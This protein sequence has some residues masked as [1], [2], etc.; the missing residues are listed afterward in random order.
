MINFFLAPKI[1]LFQN[2]NNTINYKSVYKEPGFKAIY[3]GNNVTKDVV[4]T[5]KVNSKK[6]GNYKIKYKI[7]EG[8]FT[9]E[10]TRVVK[11]RD[12][13]KPTIVLENEDSNIYVC[14]DKKYK[15][16]K[17]V[18]FDNYDGNITKNV[19]ITLRKN[20]VTYAVTD[21]SGNYT[22]ITKK[23]YY[24]DN[25][26]PNLK[27]HGDNYINL[28]LN[29]KYEELG[30]E[31]LDDCDGNIT[32]N[33]I[34]D[35]TVDTTKTGKYELVYHVT[36]SS[37]NKAEIKRVVNVI[38]KN[39]NGTIYLTF[40]DGPRTGVTNIILDILKEEGVKATFFVTNNG[41]DELIKREYDEGHTVALHT[42]SHN[43]AY[44][45]ASSEN[46]FND[47]ETVHQRVLRIT[48]YDSRIIRFPGGS[49][50]TISKRYQLGIMS[51]LTKEVLNRSYRYYDWNI[52]SGDAGETDEKE[53]VYQ[54]VIEHLSLDKVN[55]IL[56]HDIK[57][58]TRDALKDIIE[59]GKKH[60]YIFD[61]IQNDTEM[62]TQRV[63]N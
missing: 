32:K 44:I 62:V 51:Y 1:I 5:G 22:I 4:I 3:K 55:V 27:L 20:T 6:L 49:S 42:A 12:I 56:M 52:N 11:V 13:E 39:Q 16:E 63:N 21:Q 15:N 58:H 46:Y 38:K 40:D 34:I 43:Y 17:V 2:K 47:L 61:K 54:N 28:Y 36:D 48:G 59:Y 26:K 30:Y 41:P 25:E 31:A 14:P 37:N 23:I 8:Y 50:N 53:G 19:K 33:V 60:G 7:K 35:G 24:K 45:Y 10:V 9:K 18:A 29:D 57:P